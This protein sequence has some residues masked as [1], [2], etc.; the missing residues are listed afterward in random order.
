MYTL[1]LNTS[2]IKKCIYLFRD[3]L[4]G[5]LFYSPLPGSFVQ[6]C[7]YCHHFVCLLVTV[8]VHNNNNI[9]I[10]FTRRVYKAQ[11]V[12]CLTIF[13]STVFQRL[14]AVAFRGF[15]V[16][17]IDSYTLPTL[18]FCHYLLVVLIHTHTYTQAFRRHFS[19]DRV[20]C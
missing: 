7:A 11:R 17:E 10:F 18:F 12:K 15:F 9:I 5:P 19:R 1:A 4:V 2:L 13:F 8:N 3:R 20:M 16:L 6:Q 14:N